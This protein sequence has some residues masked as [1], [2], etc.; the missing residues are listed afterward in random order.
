MKYWAGLKTLNS[1]QI[2]PELPLALAQPKAGNNEKTYWWSK[3]TEVLL[4]HCNIVSNDYKQ[5]SR[6]LHTFVP[7]QPFGQLLEI[8]PT[9]SI[10]LK[11][12]S[13]IF[14]ILKYDFQIKIAKNCF[15]KS[16]SKSSR[17]NW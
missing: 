3:I 1:K 16:N 4:V 15:K 5:D 14:H 10:F 17:S 11:K 9:N 2:L 12:L 7:N 13:Q 6:V 8:S